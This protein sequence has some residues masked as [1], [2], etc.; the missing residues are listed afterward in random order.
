M[1][2]GRTDETASDCFYAWREDE[3]VWATLFYSQHHKPQVI[4]I[5]QW[6]DHPN[7]VQRVL[8]ITYFSNDLAADESYFGMLFR[9]GPAERSAD[10]LCW[11]TP[12]GESFELLSTAVLKRRYVEPVPAAE[13]FSVVGVGLRYGVADLS[14]CRSA[15]RE[16]G[17]PFHEYNGV[18]GVAPQHASG[19]LSEFVSLG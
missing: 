12:R 19:V 3:R 18:I 11:R 13:H 1:P 15:L 2:D 9:A 8:G 4:W 17:V 7:T 10:R 5:P 14:S 6:Q 16:G